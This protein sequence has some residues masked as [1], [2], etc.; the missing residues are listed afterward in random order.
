MSNK[1]KNNQNTLRLAP[2]ERRRFRRRILG[3]Y[4]REKRELPWRGEKDPYRIWVSEAMLQQTRVETIRLRYPAF[5]ERFPTLAALA[6]APLDAVLAE[7]QGL[8]YYG[9]ARNLHRAAQEVIDQDRGVMPGTYDA[10][11]ALPGVGPYMAGAI[12]SIAF[13]ERRAA[14]D[15]NVLRIM[16][17]VLNLTCPVDT[18]PAQK[19]IRKETQALVP[20]ARPGDFN[21]ALM[22]LGARICLPK[23]P[24]C[25]RCP[26]RNLCASHKTGTQHA[27]PVKTA[28]IPPAPYT[29]FQ[30]RAEQNGLVL[31][32]QRE[33]TGLFGG[34][35][36]LPG[37]MVEGHL[38]KADRRRLKAQCAKLLG[39]GWRPGRELARITRT[40]THRKILFVVHLA[41]NSGKGAPPA[42]QDGR[43]WASEE[44]FRALAVS[45]AQRA[46]WRAAKSA[47]RNL[48][49]K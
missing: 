27:L 23:N 5:I 37:F 35:W 28:K 24:D 6:N 1:T 42:S 39:P 19:T 36:E 29:L 49:G 2:P 18:L 26:V 16:S 44:D 48:E 13:Q 45:T 17:R 38:E 12:A 41:E 43:L 9:R 33:R 21:Q 8:G 4:E 20:R 31:L 3:W 25:A 7:W 11:L 22:D 40:L 10:L 30:F 34:M 14:I 32:S 15:G 47:L 46:A